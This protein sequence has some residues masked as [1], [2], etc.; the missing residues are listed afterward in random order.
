MQEN[1][2]T[3]Q[4]FAKTLELEKQL[5]TASKANGPLDKS[6]FQLRDALRES[7]EKLV[8]SD[9]EF[10]TSKDVEINLWKNVYYKVIEEFR[11][12]IR[13]VRPQK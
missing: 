9:Y 6:A 8:F 1:N 4:L 12:R 2:T 3:K 13:K 10:A 7:Y 11:K 5:R